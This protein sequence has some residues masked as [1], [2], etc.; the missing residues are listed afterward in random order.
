MLGCDG[1][2]V[3]GSRDAVDVTSE[4]WDVEVEG[5]VRDELL[6]VRDVDWEVELGVEVD[7]EVEDDLVVIDVSSEEFAGAEEIGEESDDSPS[8]CSGGSKD[9][10]GGAVW[11]VL[12]VSSFSLYRAFLAGDLLGLYLRPLYRFSS[13][14]GVP[15]G[16][17]SEVTEG[18]VFCLD[19]SEEGSGSVTLS[20]F[21][22][23]VIV[24]GL[25]GVF[26][27]REFFVGKSVLLAVSEIGMVGSGDV[28]ERRNFR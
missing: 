21:S 9:G 2:G 20:S 17:D 4:V 11:G 28:L 12:S 5:G 10:S 13:T 24:V 16:E 18:G 6:V 7:L 26:E 1:L 3:L 23:N 27:G 25:V 22:L 8:S 19:V 14:A 15:G